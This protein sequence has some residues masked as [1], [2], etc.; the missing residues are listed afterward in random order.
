MNWHFY[1]HMKHIKSDHYISFYIV[2]KG[3]SIHSFWKNPMIDRQKLLIPPILTEWF[4]VSEI[5]AHVTSSKLLKLMN[6]KT[7]VLQQISDACLKYWPHPQEYLMDRA[8]PTVT[9]VAI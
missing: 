5:S 3:L 9:V 1:K 8:Y 7:Y 6:L 2:I 4:F